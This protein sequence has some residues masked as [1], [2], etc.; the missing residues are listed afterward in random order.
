M[1]K[2]VIDAAWLYAQDLRFYN[3]FGQRFDVPGA[4]RWSNPAVPDLRDGNH[5]AFAPGSVPIPEQFVRILDAQRGDGAAPCVDVY[6]TPGVADEL[7]LQYGLTRLEPPALDLWVAERD[8]AR[9]VVAARAESA[10]P[11]V[12]IAPEDW[13]AAT[14]TLEGFV[15]RSARYEFAMAQ[16]AANDV[17]F[18]GIAI[19]ER[20][21]AA[22]ARHDG[23][24]LSRITS[25]RV[26]RDFR[27]TGLARAVLLRAIGDA[28]AEASFYELPGGD[29]SLRRLSLSIGAKCVA[30]NAHRRRI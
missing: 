4:A 14:A 7:C 27:R 2:P 22:V 12:E 5:A 8:H 3:L 19:G 30:V 24:E 26:D 20:W 23:G 10:A 18:F 11:V 15:A 16:A 13:V 25:L 29:D 9:R 17:K 21:V 28:P 1:K 6:G